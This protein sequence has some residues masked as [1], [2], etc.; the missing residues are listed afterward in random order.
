MFFDVLW[1]TSGNEIMINTR[2]SILDKI[3]ALYEDIIHDYPLSCKKGCNSCCTRNVTVTSL[4]SFLVSD[5]ILS[6]RVQSFSD[7]LKKSITLPRFIPKTTSNG[8]ASIIMSGGEEPEEFIDASWKPCPFLASSG[9]C[10]IYDVRPFHCRCM[11]SEQV[12]E[13]GGYSVLPPF[14]VTLNNVFLQYIE[15]LDKNGFVANLTDAIAWMSDS[16]NMESYAIGSGLNSL[17]TD[18]VR[19]MA[20]PF[21]MVPPEHQEQIKPVLRAIAEIGTSAANNMGR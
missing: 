11:H 21:L 13:D 1:K 3:F 17:P 19:C 7:S 6:E 9:E 20:M 14:I 12:C 18:F 5:C 4:E 8:F 15:H 2:L 10:G 16:A